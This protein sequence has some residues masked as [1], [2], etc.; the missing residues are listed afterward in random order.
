MRVLTAATTALAL[1]LGMATAQADAIKIKFAHVVAENT[2]KGQMALKFKE[3]AE[4]RLPGKVEVEVY[5]NSQLFNDNNV[6]EA[7]LLGD[8]QLAA[9]SLSKFNKYTKKL[10]VFDLPFLFKDMTAVEK[11]QSG[12]EGQKLLSSM[13]SK[14]LLG[15]GYLHNG[16][17]QLSASKELRKPSDADG[18][19]FRIQSSDVLAAQFEAVG[20]TPLK[21]PFSEVFLLLQTKAID[22][23]ENTWSNIYSKKFFEVQEHI[24]ASN[25]GLI[26]YLVVTSAEFWNDLP[27]DVRPVLEKSMK[28]AI[29]H[30][31]MIAEQKVTGDRKRI[32]DSGRSTILELS[33]AERAMWVKAMK[34]VWDKFAGEIGQDLIDAAVA[35]NN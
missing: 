28:E 22:G 13:S 23:Q 5:P 21:K 11:F 8:V 9:P 4:S 12:P 35:S 31:N 1:M 7:M 14:G 29:A 19:K 30:G 25:H 6:L 10:Q 16:L 27:D 33:D 15:L 26:D 3:L 32:A 17:K 34:P 2:P 18:L 20:A 24:T